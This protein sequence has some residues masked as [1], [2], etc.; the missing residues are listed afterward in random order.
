MTIRKYLLGALAVTLG[1]L[2]GVTLFFP[3][4]SVASSLF[5]TVADKAASRGIYVTASSAGSQGIFK[6]SFIYRGLNADLPMAKAN[7]TEVTVTPD[8]ISSM[9]TDV[10]RARVTFGKG[11]I[12]PVTRQSIG[13]NSGSAYVAAS[14][15]QIILED[16][17]FS[18]PATITGSAEVSISPL[19]LTHARLLVKV[20]KELDIMFNMLKMTNI[21]PLKKVRDG[22]WR[23]ER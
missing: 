7:L 20:P 19:K 16:I 5:L 6:K 9:T 4:D 17:S 10:K 22:E 12:I 15:N 23:I 3:W 21:L 13:W 18:G 2:M 14:K 11:S 8:I 1:L